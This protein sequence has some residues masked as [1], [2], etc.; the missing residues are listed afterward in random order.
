MNH[1]AASTTTPAAQ[2]SQYI[3][4]PLRRRDALTTT[5]VSSGQR[6]RRYALTERAHHIL[7]PLIIL[8]AV[9]TGEAQ[10]QS[11]VHTGQHC[12]IRRRFAQGRTDTLP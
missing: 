5:G 12:H 1:S 8:R 9:L 2:P 11:A 7:T 3:R 4:R 10:L 6:K